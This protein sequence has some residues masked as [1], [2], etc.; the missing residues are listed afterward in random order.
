MC[1]THTKE[2]ADHALRSPLDPQYLL[3]P[4]T[5]TVKGKWTDVP[6]RPPLPYNNFSREGVHLPSPMV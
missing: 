1:G 4:F 3:R 5:M 2:A 6:A